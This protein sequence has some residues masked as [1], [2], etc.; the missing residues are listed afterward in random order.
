[1]TTTLY[2]PLDTTV[3]RALLREIGNPAN[4]WTYGAGTATLA[5][6]NATGTYVTLTGSLGNG[7]MDPTGS[8]TRIELG[9]DDGTT[10]TVQ[11][12]IDG[13]A[14]PDIAEFLS[15]ARWVA[16]EAESGH[17]DLYDDDISYVINT[18]TTETTGHA[19]NDWA[20]DGSEPVTANLGQGDDRFL[21]GRGG[22]TLYMGAG[23]DVLDASRMTLGI[24][25]DLARASMTTAQGTL[26][27]VYGAEEIVGTDW[28]DT[29]NGGDMADAMLGGRGNDVLVGGDGADSLFGEA[30]NDTLF[31]GSGA[32]S[33]LGGESLDVIYGGPGN[34]YL[35]GGSLDDT[36]YGGSGNDS[37]GGGTSADL[38][39]GGAGDD[40]L[41]GDRLLSWT[42]F[43]NY[44]DTIYGGAGNDT[45]VSGRN[46]DL[47]YG[48]PGHDDIRQETGHATIHGG[49]G[50]DSI[51]FE[52][53]SSDSV[54]LHGDAGHDTV[55][56]QGGRA[57]LYG[58]AGND[59][60]GADDQQ[61]ALYGG[62]GDDTLYGGQDRDT[63]VGGV[64][65]DVLVGD[66]EFDP[67][68]DIP[69]QPAR[70][71]FM[72]YGLTAG[73]AVAFDNGHDR[74]EDFRINDGDVAMFHDQTAAD[75][76]I[77]DHADRVEVVHAY[78]VVDFMKTDAA[79]L[80]GF[81]A[82]DLTFVR[83]G[84]DGENQFT[85]G[86]GADSVQGGA[87]DDVLSGGLGSDTFHGGAG[88]DLL[89]GEVGQDVLRGGL[90]HDEVRG[91]LGSDI[92]YGGAGADSLHG[93]AGSDV[94]G[95]GSGPDVIR[96]Y[97]GDDTLASDDVGSYG[98][99]A[100]VNDT[101]YGGAGDDSILAG[102]G[103]DLLFGGDGNDVIRHYSGNVTIYGGD[104]DDNLYTSS[105]TLTDRL[106]HGG[107]GNDRMGGSQ[108]QDSMFGDA[109]HDS[110]HGGS[111][112]DYLFGGRGNDTVQGGDGRDTLIGGAGDDVL[113]GDREGN[114]FRTEATDTFVFFGL[115]DDGVTAFDN[116]H[117][118]IEDFNVSHDDLKFYD[119]IAADVTITEYDDR[120]E[121]SHRYGVVD[122]AKTGTD[123]QFDGFGLDDLTFA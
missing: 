30:G 27:T 31:G 122:L 26:Y 95:G 39:W 88:E 87:S 12:R 111:G 119:Q 54:V 102:G 98:P 103:S 104:G 113:Q 6:P 36:V 51:A 94:I 59:L 97:A 117:D 20:E 18:L 79:D 34:D 45:I 11:A 100:P 37:I 110:I 120:F 8:V 72:F 84:L 42:G 112:A 38:I 55:T 67:D 32:D 14:I 10:R 77:T 96:G 66:G 115:A 78:G 49:D 33:L 86:R 40:Y 123:G 29:L 28:D 93:G 106:L 16:A 48:G 70:D 91:G 105:D 85:G 47:L 9:T 13:L 83:T 24:D 89:R 71:I 69:Q 44:S 73:G 99:N 19:G 81:L 3:Q 90:G 5:L 80:D 58:G 35:G 118:R 64:G 62:S 2:A 25:A 43:S 21:L 46:A 41:H 50:N 92:L 53:P 74:I 22:G 114:F 109:G 116:G 60:L 56:A 82:E 121:L 61:D 23:Y 63:L 57:T 7:G 75:V 108:L 52:G 4:V 68:S 107:N 17:L 76:T 1:M 65:D 15:D 101:I